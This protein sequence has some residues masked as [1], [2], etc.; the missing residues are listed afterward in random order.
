MTGFFVV[1]L[2]KDMLRLFSLAVLLVLWIQDPV[3]S[4]KDFKPALGD[5]KGRIM[6]LDYSSGKPFSMPAN[7]RI[8]PGPNRKYELILALEYPQEPRANGNDTLRIS[9][10]G[11]RLD[12]EKVVSRK[13]EDGV[14]KIVT[15]TE[16]VDG[17]D[18]K[19]ALIRHIYTIGRKVFIQRKEVK[20]D[21]ETSF[22]TRNEFSFSR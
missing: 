21:N 1:F 11:D 9:E 4:C 17:N 14:L 10:R 12:G 7:V 6:Y 2:K 22:I 16:G 18:R 15:E 3:V 13:K 20:F 5:W 19:K 8:Y